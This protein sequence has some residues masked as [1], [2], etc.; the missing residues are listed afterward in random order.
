MK[1][2]IMIGEILWIRLLLLLSCSMGISLFLRF[3]VERFI[4]GS[5]LH[6][7]AN[8]GAY[9]VSMIVTVV[10]NH[11]WVEALNAEKAKVQKKD[12]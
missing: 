11:F 6:E 12:L 5:P 2:F 4:P 9:F 8:E 10:I 7:M 1:N 3:F